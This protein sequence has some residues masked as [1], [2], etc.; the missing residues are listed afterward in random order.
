MSEATTKTTTS[1]AEKLATLADQVKVQAHLAEMDAT[2]AWQTLSEN[3]SSA[4]RQVSK[5]SEKV[6]EFSEDSRYQAELALMQAKE[7][8]AMLKA[9]AEKVSAESSES[10]TLIA[11]RAKEA[12]TKEAGALIAM[13]EDGYKSLA[14]HLKH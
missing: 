2:V 5:A 14:E 13:L 3:L 11:N 1:M 9:Q 6:S 8:W 7:S 10:A 12:L 4:I